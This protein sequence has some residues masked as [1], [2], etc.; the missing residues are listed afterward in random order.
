MQSQLVVNTSVSI[1]TN[2]SIGEVPAFAAD[3]FTLRYHWSE[4]HIA[5][6]FYHET[7]FKK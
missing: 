5:N 1:C 7:L 3:I 6:S 2:R 4:I